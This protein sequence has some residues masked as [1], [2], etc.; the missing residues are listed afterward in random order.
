MIGKTISHYR[1]LSKLGEGGMGAV[2]KAEDTKLKRVVALKFLTPRALGT[3][4]DKTRFLHEAQAAAALTHAN[5]CTVFEIDEVE[6]HAFIVMECVE[7]QSLKEK[8]SSGP[9]RLDEALDIAIQVAEGLHEAHDR[10]M[11]HRDIKSA[12]IM[13]SAKGQAKVMDFG[14]AKL[15]GATK[16]TKTGT[17]VG[18]IAYMSPEQTRGEPVDHRSDIWSLGVVLYEMVTG[19]SPFR[20][21]YGEAVVYSILSESPEPVTALRTGVPVELERVI[22]KALA[23]VPDER[24]QHIDEMLVDLRALKKR[25]ESGEAPTRPT[26]VK[27]PKSKRVYWYGVIAVAAVLLMV[28]ALRFFPRDREVI[29]SIAVLPL[30]N[31]MGDPQQE[32]FVDGMTDA[33]I[34]ELSKIGALRV[35]SRTS[36]MRYKDSD[37]A[38]PEIARELGVDALVEGSVLREGGRVRITAQLIGVVPERHL[39][40]E[41]YDRDLGDVLILSSEVARAIAAGV[42]VALTPQEQARLTAERPVNLEA[43]EL[44]LRGR[45]RLWEGWTGE[46]AEEA[47]EYFRAALEK[48]PNFAEAYAALADGYVWLGWSGN[49]P[50]KEA[51]SEARTFAEKALEIDENLSEAHFAMGGV[52][53]YLDWDWQGGAVEFKRAIE[54][55]PN[56]W[57]A[58]GEYAWALVT[59]GRFEEGIAEAERM[60][61]LNPVAYP[62]NLSMVWLHYL[63]RRYDDAIAYCRQWTGLEP[64]D[65]RPY[66]DM[67]MVYGQ[68]GRYEDAVT[69]LKKSM[70]LEGAP[71]ERIAALE[72]A[73]RESGSKGY[74]TW[75]LE[76]IE[77]VGGGYDR[78]PSSAAIYY[79]RLGEKDKA[80]AWLE[81]AYEKHDAAM[82][83]LKVEP[84]WD[85][86]R[87]DPRFKDILQRMNFPED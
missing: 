86:L 22:G 5:I 11:V 33:L 16:V 41:N 29:E 63:A 48:D 31:L 10:G 59:R 19:R 70:T 68:M 47:M 12:N 3:E 1:I 85:P 37:K 27:P 9:L 21:D 30:Q 72:R 34:T 54:L 76:R 73:Y 25:L 60:F 71:Q 84:D 28:A 56:N 80:F 46:A 8:V 65:Y 49:L 58:R 75:R 52:R 4:D 61:Q 81:R 15:S 69:A 50:L 42:H 38:L 74:W 87:D 24:Y 2:Y 32:Y 67:A 20:G 78:Y 43:Y 82:F 79:A 17:T 51:S 13:V 57:G 83:R 40:A 14:L 26:K 62:A 44:Y 35:I 77:R 53:F 45:H 36:V 7:G 66:S 64:K 6:G 18:T 23:K 39:W 55:N